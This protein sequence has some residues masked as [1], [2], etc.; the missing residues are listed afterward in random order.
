M[1]APETPFIVADLQSERRRIAELVWL[2]A[3]TE[4]DDP[5]TDIQCRDEVDNPVGYLQAF[6]IIQIIDFFDVHLFSTP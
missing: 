4:S 5:G 1:S 6:T 2:A 3:E